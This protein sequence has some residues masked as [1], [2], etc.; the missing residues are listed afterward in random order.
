MKMNAGGDSDLLAWR[1]CTK[2]MGNTSPK[3]EILNAVKLK[4]QPEWRLTIQRGRWAW[5]WSRWCRNRV[6]WVTDT[7][8]SSTYQESYPSAY[9]LP[10][11]LGLRSSLPNPT[12]YIIIIIIYLIFPFL[13][14]ILHREW[15]GW[16]IGSFEPLTFTVSLTMIYW[17]LKV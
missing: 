6:V 4:L 5:L 1:M 9:S 3:L 17:L 10:P 14:P 13:V 11:P 15:K 7:T 12:M 8:S 2:P 16:R